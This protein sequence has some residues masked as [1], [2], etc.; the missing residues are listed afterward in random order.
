MLQKWYDEGKPPVFW[1]SGFYF[2][3]AFLTGVKQNYARKYTIPID[4]IDFDFDVS[5]VVIRG[6]SNGE[7]S[8][9]NTCI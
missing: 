9:M 2:T 5:I 1:V 6:K 3:Q 7:I 4:R 8:F